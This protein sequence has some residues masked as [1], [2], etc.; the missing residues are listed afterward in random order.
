[1]F[2]LDPA[3]VDA[4]L[5]RLTTPRA[6]AFV[7]YKDGSEAGAQPGRGEERPGGRDGAGDGRPGEDGDLAAEQ[8][9]QG[10]RDE[11]RP[12]RRRVHD[13]GPLSEVR[14]K[15]AALKKD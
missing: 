2:E 6:D 5:E 10:V 1:M 13:A 4:F 8:G 12:A 15:P 14:A 3:K 11:Q 9:R 7:V